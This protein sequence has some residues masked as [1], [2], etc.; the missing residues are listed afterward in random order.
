MPFPQVPQLQ[1]QP[2]SNQVQPQTN[3][4]AQSLQASVANVAG[5]TKPTKKA[6]AWIHS[7]HKERPSYPEK[8]KEKAPS[9]GLDTRARGPAEED[10]GVAETRKM[11]ADMMA[12]DKANE[13]ARQEK[14]DE[15]ERT[16][17]REERRSERARTKPRRKKSKSAKTESTARWDAPH[18]K[19]RERRYGQRY[20]VVQLSFNFDEFA[21]FTMHGTSTSLNFD[22][23]SM[24]H[25]RHSHHLIL[26]SIEQPHPTRSAHAKG[27][28]GRW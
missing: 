5:P 11:I 3:A 14:T 17:K 28:G 8:E 4:H 20:D 9:H 16:R 18:T 6:L 19:R 1:V 2:E 24:Q 26:L 12:Q 25:G 7:R 27:T 21:L 15:K 23:T 22:S 13:K 10:A